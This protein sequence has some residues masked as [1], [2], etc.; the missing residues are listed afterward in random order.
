MLNKEEYL[1]FVLGEQWGKEKVKYVTLETSLCL[2]IPFFL[3]TPRLFPLPH[4]QLNTY[5][6]LVEV[7][8]AWVLADAEVGA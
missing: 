6:P 7:N 4:L 1:D 2:R 3:H 5:D 8:R